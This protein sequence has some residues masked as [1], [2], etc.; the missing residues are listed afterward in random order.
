MS[1]P[2]VQ[3]LLTGN[4][5]MTG[6][7]VDSNSAMIAHELKELGLTISKKTTVADD[8]NL[9]VAEII[10]I[11]HQA[12][13]LIINGGLGPTIDDLTAQALAKA[14]NTTITE[15]PEALAHVTAWC[16]KRNSELNAPNLKQTM[17]PKGCDIISNRNGS[18]VGFSLIFQ[19]CIVYCTPGVPSELKIMLAEQI[20]PH[21]KQQLPDNLI[22]DVTRLQ[23]FGIGE[24]SLQKLI[25]EA[26][27]DWPESIEIGF[28]AGSPLLEVKLSTY[29]Q[30]ASQLKALWQEKLLRVLGDNFIAQVKEKPFT[31]AEHL[32]KKLTE[33]QLTITTAESCTGGLIA[34]LITSVSGASACF[35]AGYVTYS[36][37]AKS[38]MLDVP[39][40]LIEQYGAVSQQVVEAM[41]QGALAKSSADLAIAVSGVAGP[42]GGSEDKPVG[43]IWIAWGSKKAIQSEC[44]LLPYTRQ[45]FQH[46]SANITLDLIRRK[47][48]ETTQTPCY[49]KERAFQAKQ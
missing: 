20:K 27:P 14:T 7:I 25:N 6:D 35:E 28:R 11:T 32:V 33:K 37:K 1:A 5:L 40:K 12:D 46:Y 45:K 9:L 17:L 18:A 43:T 47:L 3:L 38:E 26:L 16:N 42:D 22:C 29:S 15:H 44:L 23:V 8:L 41:A 2:Q 4:E 13:I 31:L 30:K 48:N 34:S 49:I 36:N 19:N 24:S 10:T 39:S 21:I